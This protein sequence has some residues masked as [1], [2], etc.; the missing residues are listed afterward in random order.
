MKKGILIGILGTITAMVAGVFALCCI[1]D[2]NMKSIQVSN[3]LD[4]E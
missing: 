4:R 2:A 3:Y 1:E